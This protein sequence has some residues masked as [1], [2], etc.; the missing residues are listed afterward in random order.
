MRRVTCSAVAIHEDGWR[1]N[2]SALRFQVDRQPKFSSH[3][4]NTSLYARVRHGD[5]DVEMP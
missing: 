5:H 3:A 1:L 4:V 2:K